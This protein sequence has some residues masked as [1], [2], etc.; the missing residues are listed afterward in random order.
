MIATDTHGDSNDFNNSVIWYNSSD[1]DDF[2]DS[3]ASDQFLVMVTLMIVVAMIWLIY[4]IVISH[5]WQIYMH[6]Y[7][8]FIKL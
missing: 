7:S 6:S 5:D 2:S 1:L 3:L 8:D 4:I